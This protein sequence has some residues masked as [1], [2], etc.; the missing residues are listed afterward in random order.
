MAD[1][2]RLSF[3]LRGNCL[4]LLRRRLGRG[5]RRT[6]CGA[7]SSK[8]RSVGLPGDAPQHARPKRVLTYCSLTST[9]LLVACA[10]LLPHHAVYD[11][12][13]ITPNPQGKA[14]NDQE[15][16]EV[17]AMERAGNRR[18][19]QWL[20]EKMLRDLAGPMTTHDMVRGCRLHVVMAAGG[21][22]T[23]CAGLQL[24]VSFQ[25][26]ACTLAHPY[27]QF[28]NNPRSHPL[29]RSLSSSP[30][31]LAVCSRPLPSHWQ[32]HPSTPRYGI[33]SGASTA[34]R[35]HACCR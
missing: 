10:S 18:R 34:T 21:W 19:R 17:R 16:A 12:P 2:W 15:L 29:Y 26:F 25:Q 11:T 32:Q 4:L 28:V 1:H 27:S 33:C 7:S 20:N 5:G 35:R 22:W 24:P 14:S 31:P 9:L 6:S 13:S 23:A 30:F 3:G 8:P